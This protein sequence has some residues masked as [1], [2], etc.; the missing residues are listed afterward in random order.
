MLTT[1]VMLIVS[2]LAAFAF[3]QLSFRGK[4]LAF[5]LFLALMMIPNELVIITNFVT[6]TNLNLRNTFPGLIRRR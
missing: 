2:T 5:T 4:D 3:A 6:V 1:A